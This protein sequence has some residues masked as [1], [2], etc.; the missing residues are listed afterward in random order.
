LLRPYSG[1]AELI[2][3]DLQAKGVPAAAIVSFPQHADSTRTE[4]EALRELVAQHQW[5]RILLVTSTYHTRRSRYIFR[6][7]FPG[8]VSVLL[9][10]ARDSDYDPN[11]WWESRIGLKL[12]LNEAVGYPFAMWELRQSP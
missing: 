4:A 9:E 1:V 8:D 7:V 5:H 11:A 2:A 3:H 10:P 12:F 6:K